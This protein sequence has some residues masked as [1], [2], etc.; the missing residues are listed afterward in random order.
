M[1]ESTIHRTARFGLYG[2]AIGVIMLAIGLVGWLCTLALG[3]EEDMSVTGMAFVV[4]LYVATFALG[5]G[6]VGLLWPWHKHVL[7]AILVG[8]AGTGVVLGGCVLLALLVVLCTQ[9]ERLD[10]SG[11]P[12]L[13]VSMTAIVLGTLLGLRLRS[14]P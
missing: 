9:P 5:G 13:H 7:G 3:V 10:V 11:F 1:S 14:M 4:P 8:L 12:I 6:T 2:A